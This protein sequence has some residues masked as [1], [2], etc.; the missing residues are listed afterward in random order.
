M[1]K[2]APRPLAVIKKAAMRPRPLPLPSSA[3]SEA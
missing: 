1:Q 3:E 2:V